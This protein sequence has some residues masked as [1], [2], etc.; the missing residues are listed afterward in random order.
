V[1][2]HVILAA[3]GK[4]VLPWDQRSSDELKRWAFRAQHSD[5][6]AAHAHW[7]EDIRR[8]VRATATDGAVLLSADG[9]MHSVGAKL[10]NGTPDDLPPEVQEYLV[11]KGTRHLSAACAAQDS[12]SGIVFCVSADGPVTCFYHTAAGGTLHAK[13]LFMF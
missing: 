2:A 5:L 7:L 9:D 11:G 13:Q 12:M 3:E 1:A 4:T 6:V 10:P 8:F